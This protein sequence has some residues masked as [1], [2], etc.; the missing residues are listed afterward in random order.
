MGVTLSYRF[1]QLSCLAAHSQH[2]LHAEAGGKETP[3]NY[4]W[5]LRGRE[6]RTSSSLEERQISKNPVSQETRADR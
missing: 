2:N 5:G 6:H 4:L 3:W 1:E